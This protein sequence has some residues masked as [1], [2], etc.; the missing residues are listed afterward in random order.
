MRIIIIISLLTALLFSAFE[1]ISQSPIQV[2]T[3]FSSFFED[4]SP[5]EFLSHPASLSKT[6]QISTALFY[7]SPFQ[8]K[9]LNHYGAYLSSPFKTFAIGT[10]F[11][12]FGNTLYRE[13]IASVAVAKEFGHHFRFGLVASAMEVSIK[14]YG[15]TR[16]AGISTSIDYHLIETIR[17]SLA[18]HNL[19]APRIGKS[20]ELLPQVVITG[21]TYSPSRSITAVIEVEKDLEFDSRYKFGVHWRPFFPLC[22]A[23]GFVNHPVQVTGGFTFEIKGQKISYAIATHPDLSVSQVFALRISLP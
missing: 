15:S 19:N 1:R 2:A 14:N 12:T 20:G 17:W 13:S 8:L 5:L 7:S 22:I 18:Y 6:N 21:I 11:A 16:T 23:S 10:G 9:Q 3:G 4:G